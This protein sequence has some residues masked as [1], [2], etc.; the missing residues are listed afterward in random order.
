M[1][2]NNPVL[3]AQLLICYRKTACIDL[4]RGWV[5]CSLQSHGVVDYVLHAACKPI[6]RVPTFEMRLMSKMRPC[7]G[8]VSW[9]APAS[10][11]LTLCLP[12]RVI[13]TT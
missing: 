6:I 13:D 7:A 9:R 4:A 1:R 8:H 5:G 2:N 12:P 3:A 10:R 11:F